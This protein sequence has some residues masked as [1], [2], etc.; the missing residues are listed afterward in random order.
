[1]R[2][3]LR[4]WAIPLLA[5]LGS[6]VFSAEIIFDRLKSTEKETYSIIGTGFVTDDS[7]PMHAGYFTKL[8][9]TLIL[10]INPELGETGIEFQWVDDGKENSEKYK[11]YIRR[12]RLFQVDDSGLEKNPEHLADL[13]AA[14][15]AALHPEIVAN[16]MLERREN[17]EPD[18]A[19]GFLFAW[20]DELWSVVIDN[21]TGRISSLHRRLQHEVHG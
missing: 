8:D 10:S 19:D 7:H 3:L 14:T 5:M 6:S 9:A 11:Y 2:T 13:S 18:R 16:A 15:V 21:K 4:I 12:G 20:N 1:M 17:L